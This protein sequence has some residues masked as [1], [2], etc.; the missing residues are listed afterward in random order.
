MCRNYLQRFC[1]QQLTKRPDY[2]ETFV[3]LYFTDNCRLRIGRPRNRCSTWSP[4]SF[5][6]SVYYGRF[7]MGL[8]WPWS[9]VKHI[10]SSARLRIS[11]AL[12]ALSHMPFVA[13]TGTPL[14]LN[15]ESHSSSRRRNIWNFYFLDVN[16]FMNKT[17]R[18]STRNLT[19]S[20]FRAIIVALEK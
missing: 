4:Q 2:N 6:F 10:P 14:F 16:K 20:C 19:L 12:Y 9:A 15:S 1:Q 8:R 18:H 11:R 7:P 13:Y 3:T 17:Y 5:L